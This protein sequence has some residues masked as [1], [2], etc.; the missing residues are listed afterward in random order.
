M[1]KAHDSV[2]IEEIYKKEFFNL[3]ASEKISLWRSLPDV[4]DQK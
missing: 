2:G 1:N 4:R 3:K